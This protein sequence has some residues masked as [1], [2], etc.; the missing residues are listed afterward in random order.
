MSLCCGR[1]DYFVLSISHSEEGD[2]PQIREDEG[3]PADPRKNRAPQ[4]LAL[5]L[6]V[7]L[8]FQRVRRGFMDVELVTRRVRAE[9]E[10]MPGMTLTVPQAT[11]LFGIERET[12]KAVVERLVTACYL[13]WTASGAFT[14]AAR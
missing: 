2:C 12:C 6:L 3:K 7:L 11:R 9:F 13:K 14:R 10:E 5:I 4:G 1:H 8:L